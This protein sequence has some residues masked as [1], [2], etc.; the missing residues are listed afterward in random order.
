MMIKNAP[1]DYNTYDI[2]FLM[3]TMRKIKFLKTEKYFYL[4]VYSFKRCLSCF[5]D[6]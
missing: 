5:R 2:L 1:H 6:E 3:D 4:I